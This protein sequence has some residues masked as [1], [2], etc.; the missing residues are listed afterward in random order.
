MRIGVPREGLA[1]ETRVALIPESV[2]KL[3]KAGSSVAVES[4]AGLQ[5]GFPD[6]E[7][8]R[9]GAEILPDA[10]RLFEWA[11]LILKVRPPTDPEIERL[12]ERHI[13]IGLLDPLVDPDRIRR[14]AEKKVTSFALELMPRISRAQS[15]DVL[16]SMSAVGGYKAVLIAAGHLPKFFPLLMTAAGTI[17]AAR[18]FVIGAGVAGL[19]AIATARRLG[20][21]VEAYDV[22]PVVREQVR[23]LGA[24]FVELGVEAEDAETKGGYARAQS[25][26]FYRRQQEQMARYVAAADVVITTALVPGRAAPK[27]VTEE[28]VRSMRPGSVIVDM[29][30][31]QGGNCALTEAGKTVV[32]HGVTI[33]GLTNLPATMPADASRLFSRNVTAF[34]QHVVRGGAIRLD[35]G[36]EVVRGPLI[37]HGGELTNERVR[38]AIGSGA[39]R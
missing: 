27:L 37:T 12:R 15:M 17:P 1:G 4:G 10:G 33:C 34:L 32:R 13:L 35:E 21:V 30:A 39:D 5:A 29:A 20:A 11:E 24:R 22:R 23:S 36:D 6:D 28:A 16:S 7:Y 14:L 18:V 25:E 31:E 38:R 3:I 2:E 9:K 26:D 19:Q 8:R